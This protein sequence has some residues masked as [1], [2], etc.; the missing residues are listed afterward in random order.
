MSI[1][2]SDFLLNPEI[3]FLNHGS[4]GATPKKVFREYQEWQRRLEFQPVEFIARAYPNLIA[5]ARQSLA[6]YLNSDKDDLVYIQSP[7]YGVNLVV[8]SLNLQKND[9]VLVSNHEYGAC[10]N[11]WEYHSQKQG[12]KIIEQEISWPV[13]NSEQILEE[14]WQGVNEN[15][16]VIF[17]SHICSATALTMPVEAIVKRAKAA[18]IIS[19]IDG[20]HAPSQIDLD[21]KDL[22]A[23][24]YIGAC[25]KWLCAPK[26]SSFLYVAPKMQ[27]MI[28]PLVVSWGWG[29]HSRMDYGS[30]MLNNTQYTGTRDFSE[31]L[32][33]STAIDF[34]KQNNWSEIRANCHTL[35]DQALDRADKLENIKRAY[36][37]GKGLYQQMGL[38]EI[39]SDVDLDEIKAKLYDD[40]KIEIP[41]H[42]WNGHNFIRISVQAYNNKKDIDI[43][44]AALKELIG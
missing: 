39:V 20:A 28:E 34:Q 8:H 14:F 13:T 18:G 6:T 23:D 22:G 1:S 30:Q 24:F 26:G 27:D 42:E 25:H 35:L 4:Y 19:I 5:Q 38:L 17:I 36:P 37:K 3:T 21:L 31:Y 2:K 43:L 11:T 16:K 40:Y 29:S 32:A 41:V 33:V 10:L 9:E 44:I 7:T 12:Y 15:T